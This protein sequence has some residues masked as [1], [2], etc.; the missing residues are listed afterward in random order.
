LVP[1]ATRKVS[2]KN[3]DKKK[4]G[5]FDEV[6]HID[7]LFNDVIQKS[8]ST[9]EMWLRFLLSAGRQPRAAQMGSFL[10]TARDMNRATFMPPVAKKEEPAIR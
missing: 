8:D 6:A 1:G 2:N 7:P 3:E 5:R 9:V 10:L 4:G